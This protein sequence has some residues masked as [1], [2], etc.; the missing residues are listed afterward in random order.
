[1]KKIGIEPLMVIKDLETMRVLADPLRFQILE[2]LVFQPLTI[3][4][5]AAKLGL[6]SGKLYYHFNLMEKHGL[7]RV[8]QT[9]MV[10]NMV[11]KYYRASAENYEFDQSL[12]SFS[13]EQGKENL[14]TY[15][16]TMLES[17]KQDV[18]RSLKA[19]QSQLDHGA[20][21]HPRT[22]VINRVTNRLTEAQVE[23][24][25]TRLCALFEEFEALDNSDEPEDA[26]QSYA[27]T[28]VF[29]PGF[30]YDVEISQPNL[31]DEG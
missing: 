8:V 19:R 4:Q 16:I 26:C 22:G 17:V 30:Y 13:S 3:N 31:K 9:H 27:L 28:T 25:Q 15:V 18:L 11:E 7:I 2:A 23:A 21:E 1:M 29:F 20:V 6:A 14:L 5:A 10:G 12:I 24:F